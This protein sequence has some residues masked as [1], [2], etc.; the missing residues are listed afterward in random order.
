MDNDKT[1]SYRT[2][3]Y[4]DKKIVELVFKPECSECPSHMFHALSSAMQAGDIILDDVPNILL[5]AVEKG[6][7]TKEEAGEVEQ[8]LGEFS[9]ETW[10]KLPDN[11]KEAQ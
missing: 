3:S 9:D 4:R 1:L 2:Y 7:F 8:T 11:Q 5:I 10:Y 6:W